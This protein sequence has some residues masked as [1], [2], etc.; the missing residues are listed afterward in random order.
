MGI[1]SY[2][3][4]AI[5]NTVLFLLFGILPWIAIAFIMQ[6]LSNSIRKSLAKLLGIQGY[7]Y[8]TCP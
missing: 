8:L 4:S 1:I 5:W 7:I 2:V 6:L 3:G